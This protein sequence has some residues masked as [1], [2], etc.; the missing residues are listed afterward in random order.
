MLSL[1]V[2]LHDDFE[3]GLKALGIP[4][5]SVIQLVRETAR[6]VASSKL[7]VSSYP[8]DEE[9]SSVGLYKYEW[10]YGG[11]VLYVYYYFLNG[12]PLELFR[13]SPL[14]LKIHETMIPGLQDVGKQFYRQLWMP[15]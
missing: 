10:S 9:L 1:K 15:N 8:D 2:E 14:P 7:I 3:E 13:I 5:T 12:D 11:G 6:F 4:R